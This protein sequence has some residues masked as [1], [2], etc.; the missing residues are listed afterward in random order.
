MHGT[1][2]KVTKLHEILPKK[3]HCIAHLK[4]SFGR[5]DPE[6]Y[7]RSSKFIFEIQ[8]DHHE[9]ILKKMVQL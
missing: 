3:W 5:I 2:G 4:F 7:L 8:D 1:L 6:W 9:Y